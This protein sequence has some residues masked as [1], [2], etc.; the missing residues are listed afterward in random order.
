VRLGVAQLS[1]APGK[2]AENRTRT[3]ETIHQARDAG[4]EL[5]V[6]PELATTGYVFADRDAA[7]RQAELVPHGPTVRAW[8]AAC[9][10]ARMHV[11]AGILERAGEDVYDT[12]VLVGPQGYIGAYR[13]VHL[14][15]REKTLFRAGRNWEVFDTPLGRVGLLVCF[16][17]RFPE[18]PRILALMG[19][20]I[21]CVP[22]TWTDLYKDSPWDE[23]G[24]CMANYLALAH[25]YA[26]RTIIACADRI[27]TEDGVRYLGCSLI[28][29]PFGKVVSGPVPPE[30]EGIFFADVDP[31]A[32]LS[33]SL[34]DHN[35]L[36][37]DRRSDLYDALLSGGERRT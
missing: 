23:R 28:V 13:K 2:P 9:S 8:I 26:N 32:A 30:V 12:A 37:R 5:L 22:T 20:E 3:L 29:D 24:F 34:G 25:A 31:K 15:D 35:D 21:I 6:L 11:V 1:L 4:V 36:W 10:Q 18:A 19:A 16:D 14:F 7:M 33:K 27:G 17:L